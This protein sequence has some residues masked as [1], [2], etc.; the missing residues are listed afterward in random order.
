MENGLSQLLAYGIYRGV[1]SGWPDSAYIPAADA[2]A[3]AV[4]DNVD[5]YG[6]VQDVCSAKSGFVTPGPNA[7]GQAWFIMLCAAG[8][9][10]QSMCA[11]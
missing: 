10:Y 4:Q 2:M 7:E 6:L 9:K 8:A 1:M 11:R 5:D 3:A